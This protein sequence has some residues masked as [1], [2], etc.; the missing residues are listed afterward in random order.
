[1]AFVS[2]FW[3][4][5][6]SVLSESN[7]QKNEQGAMFTPKFGQQ[8]ILLGFS[9]ILFGALAA[10]SGNVEFLIC[11]SSVC[12]VSSFIFEENMYMFGFLC[13]ITGILTLIKSFDAFNFAK[14]KL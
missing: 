9:T 3:S 10:A 11:T 7:S 2:L 6:V 14:G 5:F 12:N 13:L 1:M 8:L 4:F